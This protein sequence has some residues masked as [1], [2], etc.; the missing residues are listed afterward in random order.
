MSGQRGQRRS[1]VTSLEENGEGRTRRRATRN[2]GEKQVM[3]VSHLCLFTF[4]FA[5]HTRHT[6]T[7]P[8]IYMWKTPSIHSLSLFFT[9]LLLIAFHPRHPFQRLAETVASSSLSESKRV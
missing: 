6:L 2:G 8:F 9:S 1:G 7:S 3:E 5:S 4:F